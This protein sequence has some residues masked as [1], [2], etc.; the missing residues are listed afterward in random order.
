VAFL[1]VWLVCAIIGTL[2]AAEVTILTL[3]FGLVA[4]PL[5]FFFAIIGG[6]FA[7]L[8]EILSGEGEEDGF[9]DSVNRFAWA[10]LIWAGGVTAT[11]WRRLGRFLSRDHNSAAED[12]YMTS[13]RRDRQ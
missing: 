4:T 2:I 13:S 3:A 10:P 9:I 1:L 5:T 8:G 11:I 12:F 7:G 6:V